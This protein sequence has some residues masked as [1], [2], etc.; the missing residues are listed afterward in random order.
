MKYNQKVYI[1]IS[2]G[3]AKCYSNLAK[4]IR[5]TPTISYFSIYRLLLDSNKAE[6]N[7]YTIFKTT[8][9]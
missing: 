3:K 4:A 5:N 1:V 6:I 2:D 7:G 8:L 9:L